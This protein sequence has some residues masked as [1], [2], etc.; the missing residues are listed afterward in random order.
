MAHARTGA[1]QRT[2]PRGELFPLMEERER[3][4]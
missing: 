2:L 4:F 1:L 3:L